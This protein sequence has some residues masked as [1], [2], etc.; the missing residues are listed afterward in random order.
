[1]P[2]YTDDELRA[3]PKITCK[4][5]ADYLGIAPMAVSIGVRMEC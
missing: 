1:M 5:A 3:L 2:K 4:I